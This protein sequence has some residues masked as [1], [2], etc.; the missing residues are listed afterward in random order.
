MSVAALSKVTTAFVWIVA[1]LA[2]SL[3]KTPQGAR[4]RRHSSTLMISFLLAIA[5]VP[6]LL[7]NR[8]ADSVKSDNPFTS[9]LT[10]ENLSEWN[11]GTISQRLDFSNWKTIYDRIDQSIIGI[12]LV[13]FTI[14]VLMIVQNRPPALHVKWLMLSSLAGPM[15]FFNLYVVHDYYLVAIFPLIVLLVATSF[16]FLKS[17]IH[18]SSKEY[19]VAAVAVIIIATFT[20]QLGSSYM[21]NFRHEGGEPAISSLIAER[22]LPNEE[23]IIIGCDWDPTYL[24][25]ADRKGL[26]LMDGRY[27]KGQISTAMWGEYEFVYL[28]NGS[29]SDILP[30]NMQIE[31]IH[32]NLYK[33]IQ[34]P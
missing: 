6:S 28:C 31:P 25:F 30:L 8:Y 12:G 34:W 5:L 2:Y 21:T 15:V 24:Y 4:V 16:D 18:V 29:P 19:S 23:T 10:S 33:I 7:W 3:L 27:D 20:S 9:W 1:V 32:E 14:A 17:M 13:V 26:M 11:F 22:T